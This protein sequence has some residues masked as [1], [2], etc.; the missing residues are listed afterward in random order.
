MTYQRDRYLDDS[1]DWLVSLELRSRSGS[2]HSLLTSLTS[3]ER[4]AV[5][6]AL[7]RALDSIVPVLRRRIGESNA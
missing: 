5:G 6:D 7:A 2:M 3:E 4:E 1:R